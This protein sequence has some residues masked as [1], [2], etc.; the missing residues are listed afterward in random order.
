MVLMT[1]TLCR[2]NGSSGWP[3]SSRKNQPGLFQSAA[4]VEQNI[5]ARDF[6]SH[7]EIVI[8]FQILHNHVGKVM[9]VDDHFANPKAAQ[10]GQA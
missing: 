8:G 4:G 10:T 9:H 1:S 5:F 6:N 3:E 7:A 2:M